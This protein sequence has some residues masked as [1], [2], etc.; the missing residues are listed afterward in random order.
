M[1]SISVVKKYIKTKM[2]GINNQF[3]LSRKWI[4]SSLPRWKE[5]AILDAK[6]YAGFS[7]FVAAFEATQSS[8]RKALPLVPGALLV[9][10]MWTLSTFG[11]ETY[12]RKVDEY[13]NAIAIGPLAATLEFASS[14]SRGVTRFAKASAIG[15]IGSG[16]MIF[17]HRLG[18]QLDPTTFRTSE[19][20]GYES[21]QS[22]IEQFMDQHQQ[23]K[24]HEH[25]SNSTSES[26]K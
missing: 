26:I 6:A 14:K 15:L 18:H 10:G 7:L 8:L 3:E 20:K 23:G 5:R 9:G 4:K 25:G 17:L 24:N 2:A 13:N 11:V 21:Y 22:H 12:R 16:C 19:P 1:Y